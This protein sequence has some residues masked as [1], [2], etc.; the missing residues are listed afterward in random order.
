MKIRRP[1]RS[2]VVF[3]SALLARVY[4]GI[5]L[6]LL[7]WSMLPLLL[8]WQPTVVSSGSMSPAVLPGDVLIAEPVNADS[9]DKKLLQNGLVPLAKD[10]ANPGHLFTH[11][12]IGHT[13]EG[14]I[15]QGDANPSPDTQPLTAESIIGIERLRIPSSEFPHVNYAPG[16]WHCRP[17]SP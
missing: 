11:R 1:E 14:Y 16:T 10:P 9:A 5:V 13:G 15:T 4:I 2:T 3:A 6:G 7:T 17:F 8:G 12:I